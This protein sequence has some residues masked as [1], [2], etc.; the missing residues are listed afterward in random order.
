MNP[1][2]RFLIKDSFT[3]DAFEKTSKLRRGS[4]FPKLLQGKSK[5]REGKISRIQGLNWPFRTLPPQID[6]DFLQDVHADAKMI[7]MGLKPQR[8]YLITAQA[9]GAKQRNTM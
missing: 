9:R 2:F 4:E 5:I 6:E 7:G 1:E 8:Y 3:L